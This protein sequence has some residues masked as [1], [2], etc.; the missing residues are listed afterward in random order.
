MAALIRTLGVWLWRIAAA[1]VNGVACVALVFSAYGGK[2]NPAHTTVGSIAAMVFPVM[3]V[4]VIALLALNLWR[5]RRL[6]VLDLLALAVCWNPL[7]DFCPLNFSRPSA[8]EIQADSVPSLNVLTY[9]VYGFAPFASSAGDT[10]RQANSTLEYVLAQDADVVLLQESL[11]NIGNNPVV[12]DITAAQQEILAVRYPYR[13]INVRGMG[14]LSKY[15]FE[16]VPLHYDDEWSFDVCRYDVRI[17]RGVIHLFNLHLQ[18][19]GLTNDDK[20]LYRRITDGSAESDADAM[21]NIRSGLIAKLSA[22]FRSRA[23]QAEVVRGFV[24]EAGGNVLLCGDF[25]DIP[26]CYASRVIAGDDMADAYREAGL[27]PAVTYH[28]DRFYFRIDQMFY[29]GEI[30]PLRV[31]CD[32]WPSSDHYPLRAIFRLTGDLAK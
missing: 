17:G 18:S 28:A 11:Q 5:C 25:N 29:R 6:A 21:R 2:I 14:I 1:A 27:G 10:T 23:V 30:L 26:G 4:V 12:K 9:N 31:W 7:L 13:Y 15:P 19:I 8:A 24:D 22:A 16:H 3:L 32:R 20:E